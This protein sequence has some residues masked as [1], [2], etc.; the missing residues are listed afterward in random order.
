[1]PCLHLIKKI[2]KQTKKNPSVCQN[3]KTRQL[4]GHFRL[5]FFFQ[6]SHLFKDVKTDFLNAEYSSSF[7]AKQ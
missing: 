3:N 6:H 2:C 1:M 5:N 4:S 7:G